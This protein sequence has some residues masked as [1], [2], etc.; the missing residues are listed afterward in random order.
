MF[1]FCF[2]I[3]QI[4]FLINNLYQE[5]FPFSNKTLVNLKYD[6]IR[7]SFNNLLFKLN[8]NSKEKNMKQKCILIG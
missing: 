8:S 1:F 7:F 5:K 6:F 2:S 4:L 3:F